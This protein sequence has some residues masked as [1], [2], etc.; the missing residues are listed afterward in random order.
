MNREMVLEV[1][2]RQIYGRRLVYPI[3]ETAKAFAELLGRRTLL[4]VDLTR[5]QAL[6]YVIQW[7]PTSLILE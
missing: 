2:L 1:Q 3:N 4:E 6:G 5:L 7:V